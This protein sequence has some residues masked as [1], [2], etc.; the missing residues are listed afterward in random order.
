MWLVERGQLA[1][2][3]KV[4]TYLPEA[5]PA[6]RNITVRQLLLH[7]SGLPAVV[8]LSELAGGPKLATARILKTTPLDPPAH[9]TIQRPAS[10]S[11]IVLE[12]AWSP[13]DAFVHALLD[14]GH[15]VRAM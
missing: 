11:G 14:R 6:A 1:L 15:D 3:A 2:D 10:S 8:P 4:A 7:T 5:A 12:R 9:A 13:L